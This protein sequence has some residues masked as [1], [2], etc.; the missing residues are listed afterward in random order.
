M[1]DDPDSQCGSYAAQRLTVAQCANIATTRTVTA[2]AS[3][4]GCTFVLSMIV[5]HKTYRSN[6]AQRLVLWMTVAAFFQPIPYMFPAAHAS[7]TAC[8]TQAF[9]VSW[10][11]WA[12]LLWVCSILHAVYHAVCWGTGL[13]MALIPVMLGAYGPGGSWCWIDKRH[14][15]LRFV[16]WYIPLFLIIAGMIAG[17]VY[18]LA[19]VR[20]KTKAWS[21]TYNPQIEKEKKW[22]NDQVNPVKYYPVLYLLV[23]LCPLINRIQ[24]A[25][26]PDHPVYELYLLQ[27]VFAPAQGLFNAVYYTAKTDRAVWEQCTITGIRRSLMQGLGGS[28]I[29]EYRMGG[30]DIHTRMIDVSSGEDDDDDDDDDII[31]Q[32][33]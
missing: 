24:N 18:V 4:A 17:S 30:S 12:L 26:N 13:V 5:L 27:A 10:L 23:S 2:V 32:T 16:L 9:F 3:L 28:T 22:M 20:R 19:K 1:A 6:W 31:F 14:T 21:G 25:A 29:G 8:I 15:S 7:S 33:N 11:N